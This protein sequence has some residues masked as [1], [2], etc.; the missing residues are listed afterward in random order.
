MPGAGDV[1]ASCATAAVGGAAA[2]GAAAIGAADARRRARLVRGVGSGRRSVV[3]RASR[4]V[5]RESRDRE[6]TRKMAE[7]THRP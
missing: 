7:H 3:A 5:R 2:I 6:E 1:A 4:R